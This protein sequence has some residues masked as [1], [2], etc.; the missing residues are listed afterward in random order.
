[1]SEPFAR[2]RHLAFAALALLQA[3][4]AT[5]TVVLAALVA[6]EP[7][8]P[9]LEALDR[10]LPLVYVSVL[11]WL[12]F[13][14]FDTR[15]GISIVPQR[16]ADLGVLGGVAFL[17][18]ELVRVVALTAKPDDEIAVLANA[19]SG[20]YT[21]ASGE[22]MLGWLLVGILATATAEEIVH[23]AFVLRAFEGYLDR[24]SAL[25]AHALVFELTHVFI[26]GY[27]FQGGAWIAPALIYGYAFQRTR[28]LAVPVLMHATSLLVF[29]LSIVW[30]VSA[31][32]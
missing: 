10:L 16:W 30:R 29:H 20:V 23:R 5:T 28:S 15:S 7:W 22:L 19:W 2:H 17:V 6:L 21:E 31:G 25:L 12:A 26:Y 14:C 8:N 27:G 9:R 1:M 13:A 24:W 3:P 18:Q 11:A 32:G 4:L